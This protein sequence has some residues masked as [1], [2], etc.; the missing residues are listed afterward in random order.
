MQGVLF[1]VERRP[2]VIV[3]PRLVDG[4]SKQGGTQRQRGEDGD[5]A[6]ENDAEGGAG[7]NGGDDENG[8]CSFLVVDTKSPSG[9]K[10]GRCINYYQ[11]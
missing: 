5:E 1:G 11:E 8:G 6:T 7:K 2:A 3:R 4:G 10:A 9:G